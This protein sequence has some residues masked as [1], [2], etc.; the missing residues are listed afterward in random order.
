MTGIVKKPTIVMVPGAWHPA[1]CFDL[2]ASSLQSHGYETIQVTTPTVGS[3][4]PFSADVQ[5]IRDAIKS[6]S[7]AGEVLLF[8]HSYGGVPGCCAVEGLLKEDLKEGG[9]TALVFCTAWMLDVG[10]AILSNPIS[11]TS[12]A[13]AASNDPLE[14][15]KPRGGAAHCFYGD[16]SREEQ[17]RWLGMLRH[18]DFD[19]IMK[20]PV[21]YAAWK[22][23]PSTYIVCTEDK[24]ISYETQ[25]GLVERAKKEGVHLRTEQLE[26]SHSPFLSMPEAVVEAIRRAALEMK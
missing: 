9:V 11:Y 5:A 4:Q 17:E 6:A 25:L 2:I 1:S 20:S 7:D 19:T 14:V 8:M 12:K 24:A 22:H 3:S 10:E 15:W 21:T 18:Q 26:A 16:L 13:R 23:V